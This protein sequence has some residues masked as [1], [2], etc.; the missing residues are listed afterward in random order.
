MGE[1]NGQAGDHASFVGVVRARRR[2]EMTKVVVYSLR[3][4][5][6]A[7]LCL[8]KSQKSAILEVGS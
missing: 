6:S 5:K 4:M 1:F 7:I 8:K 2:G 3:P